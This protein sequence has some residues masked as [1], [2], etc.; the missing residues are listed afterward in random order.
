MNLPPRNVPSVR[1]A[2]GLFGRKW[3][4]DAASQG[5]FM[6]I[7]SNRV[8]PAV[9]AVSVFFMAG[10]AAGHGAVARAGPR[11]VSARGGAVLA[12]VGERDVS[13][14]SQTANMVYVRSGEDAAT[15]EIDAFKF[16]VAAARVSWDVG[17]TLA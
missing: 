7:S 6:T 8:L 17:Q 14:R 13:A 9:L 10:C 2:I 16:S 4:G 1:H 12:K 5:T 3:T 15:F 11:D